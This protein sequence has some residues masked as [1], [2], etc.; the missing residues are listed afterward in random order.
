MRTIPAHGSAAD[1][2]D[3][4]PIRSSGFAGTLGAKREKLFLAQATVLSPP[5]YSARRGDEE[6]KTSAIEKL[7][8]GHACLGISEG[9]V[10]QRHLGVLLP[11]VW[12]AYPQTYPQ[13]VWLQANADEP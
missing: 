8:C 11:G 6:I 2:A 3:K 1:P 7:L 13:I 12:L 5:S 9:W 10:S 4:M